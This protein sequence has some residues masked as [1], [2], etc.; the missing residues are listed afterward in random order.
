MVLCTASAHPDVSPPVLFLLGLF[1]F[2]AVGSGGIKPNVVVLGADQFDP[3]VPIEKVQMDSYFNYFYWS[4][5]IGA[6]FSFGFLAYL[7][8]NGIGAIPKSH[9]FFASFVIPAVA[10]AAAILVFTMG[11][12]KYIKKPAVS[13]TCAF[14]EFDNPAPYYHLRWLH[15]ANCVASA[16]WSAPVTVSTNLCDCRRV[17]QHFRPLLV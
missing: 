7:A 9:G 3:T 4:I 2:V 6:T 16:A 1:L 11:L 10:M 14:F 8:V 13:C 15:L 17:V 5:N 12:S